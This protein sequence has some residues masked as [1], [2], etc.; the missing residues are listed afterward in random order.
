MTAR[1]EVSLG[2]VQ[3]TLL[4]FLYARAGGP[5]ASPVCRHP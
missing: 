2:M 3:E 5:A 4:T 1:R